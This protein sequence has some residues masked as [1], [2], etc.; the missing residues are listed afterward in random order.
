MFL[1]SRDTCLQTVNIIQKIPIVNTIEKYKP[2][3]QASSGI[4]FIFF[5]IAGTVL[6]FEF[7]MRIMLIFY[8][9]CSESVII[10][11]IMIIIIIITF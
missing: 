1:S 4:V 5:L 6:C 10:I 11:F 9:S 8:Y 2:A 7:T 3:V